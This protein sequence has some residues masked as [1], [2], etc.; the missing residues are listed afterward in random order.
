M[1]VTERSCGW[2]GCAG[3][4]PWSGW[5]HGA[6]P[7]QRQVGEEL[8]PGDVLEFPMK[9]FLGHLSLEEEEWCQPLAAVSRDVSLSTILCCPAPGQV[10][11]A[12]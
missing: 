3:Q 7:C 12:G 9:S 4:G 10:R 11:T 6:L 8:P 2:A 5:V 1:P